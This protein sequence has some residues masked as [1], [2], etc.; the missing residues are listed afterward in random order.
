MYTDSTTQRW[1]GGL[2]TV[3]QDQ[4]TAINRPNPRTSPCFL[5]SF[6]LCAVSAFH[7][8]QMPTQTKPQCLCRQD[9]SPLCFHTVG[10][11]RW[12]F[13]RQDLAVR[14]PAKRRTMRHKRAFPRCCLSVSNAL[15]IQTDYTLYQA[16][17]SRYQNSTQRPGARASSHVIAN[18]QLRADMNACLCVLCC[19]ICCTAGTLKHCVE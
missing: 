14:H 16:N 15:R 13:R 7:Q 9:V 5:A 12:L 1:Q 19:C 8:G 18:R 17:W 3:P 2:S 10:V 11:P 4:G 6:L